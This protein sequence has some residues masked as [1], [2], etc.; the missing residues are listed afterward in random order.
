MIEALDEHGVFNLGAV[1]LLVGDGPER[2]RLEEVIRE[3]NLGHVVKITGPVGRTALLRHL[4]HMD[5][6]LQPAATPYASPMKLFE[7]LA[8]GKAVVAPDQANIR[9]VVRDGENALFFSPGDWKGL[10][11]QVETLVMNPGLRERI[12][13][14]GRQS[15]LSRQRTWLANAARVVEMMS[16]GS[17]DRR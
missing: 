7:Y 14:A 15:M 2:L 4:G 17:Y 8:A 6:A 9:E 10:A 5:I 3:K 11:G 13:R 16:G 1:L 12:G